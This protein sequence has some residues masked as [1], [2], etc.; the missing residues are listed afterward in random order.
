M[1]IYPSFAVATVAVTLALLSII[2]I[3]AVVVSLAA[4]LASGELML[5]ARLDAGVSDPFAT[6]AFIAN[7]GFACAVSFAFVGIGRW[8]KWPFVVE[9]KRIKAQGLPVRSNHPANTDARASAV[10][11]RTPLPARAGCWER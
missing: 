6:I 1:W 5:V 8:R 7:W 10:L 9:K 3:P 11:S 2:K 4:T